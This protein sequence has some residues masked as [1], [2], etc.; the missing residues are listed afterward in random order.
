MATGKR[1]SPMPAEKARRS[2]GPDGGAALC[3]TPSQ[4][5]ETEAITPGE[6]T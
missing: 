4:A 5:A 1:K 2:L 6:V 3:G